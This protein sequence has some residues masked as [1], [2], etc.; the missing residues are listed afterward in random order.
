MHVGLCSKQYFYDL[1]STIAETRIE[2]Q[3]LLDDHK[4]RPFL[5]SPERRDRTSFF[6]QFHIST[7]LGQSDCCPSNSS[8]PSRFQVPY[9]DSNNQSVWKQCRGIIANQWRSP[10][11]LSSK[12][13]S[14]SLRLLKGLPVW[15]FLHKFIWFF[16][17]WHRN[18]RYISRTKPRNI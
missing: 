13:Q 17:L 8:Y 16:P 5:L 15:N 4:N 12:N 7:N 6:I 9:Q 1:P 11:L 2:N 10:A 3:K 14:C 18:F